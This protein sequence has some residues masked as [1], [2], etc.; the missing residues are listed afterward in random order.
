MAAI[1]KIK[2][3]ARTTP[4]N[5]PV[6]IDFGL[7]WTINLFVAFADAMLMICEGAPSIH[8]FWATE[9]LECS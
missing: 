7:F 9:K 1:T 6:D 5:A 2:M 8:T 4:T 3:T